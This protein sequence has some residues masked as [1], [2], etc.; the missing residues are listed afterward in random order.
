M[1]Y[2]HLTRSFAFS[3]DNS[4]SDK[5]FLMLSNHVRFGLPLL[6]FLGTSSTTTLAY[7][8]VF[9]SQYMSIP[10]QVRPSFLPCLWYFSHFCCPSNSF[11]PNSVHSSILSSLFPP[12]PTRILCFLQRPMSRHRT[13]L[14]VLSSFTLQDH[15]LNCYIFGISELCA[16]VIRWQDTGGCGS[17]WRRPAR[18]L[19]CHQSTAP[20]DS[21]GMTVSS[22]NTTG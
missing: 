6:L 11:I 12:H 20:Q 10:L 9:S 13:S 7:I 4:L 19:T 1:R 8:F 15:D 17:V 2:L 5:S 22:H 14:L 16:G 21:T 3:P 18:N